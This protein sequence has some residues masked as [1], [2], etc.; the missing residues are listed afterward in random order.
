M[1]AILDLFPILKM[2]ESVSPEV[3]SILFQKGHQTL[4]RKD[5]IFSASVSSDTFNAKM[6]KDASTLIELMLNS[7]VQ[8][9]Y[10]PDIT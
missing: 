7:H 4:F 6:P 2:L 8:G 10:N 3:I 5:K 1:D 9:Q